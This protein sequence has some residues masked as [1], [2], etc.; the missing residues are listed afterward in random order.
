M[1]PGRGAA[2]ARSWR[3]REACP[4]PPASPDRH[5]SRLPGD[6][7]AVLPS[8]LGCGS[9]SLPSVPS[10]RPGAWPPTYSPHSSGTPKWDTHGP[11]PAPRPRAASRSH[12]KGEQGGSGELGC[13]LPGPTGMEALSATCPPA[14]PPTSG[15]GARASRG[16]CAP[17]RGV[18]S[19]G[20][21]RAGDEERG[22][23]GGGT[24]LSQ[25]QGRPRGPTALKPGFRGA[26][27]RSW[28]RPQRP[29]GRGRRG[30]GRRRAA[31]AAHSH[32]QPAAASPRRHP[33]CR[34]LP[35]RPRPLP[36]RASLVGLEHYVGAC[37]PVLVFGSRLGLACPAPC[38]ARSSTPPAP[39]RRAEPQ[40]AGSAHVRGCLAAPGSPVAEAP[41]ELRAL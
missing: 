30:C 31:L 25:G 37:L 33:R 4:P 3:W 29:A 26:E 14:R 21:A 9:D 8:H 19:P 41:P 13:P 11:C 1:R 2:R 5:D 12:P 16:L 40:R 10:F 6:L 32:A 38:T 28:G 39:A 7:E 36:K 17:W 15:R 27:A 20:K 35:R 18:R 23:T 24:H 22:R 34:R